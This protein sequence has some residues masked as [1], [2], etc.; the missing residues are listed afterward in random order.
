[1]TRVG[2]VAKKGVQ[3]AGSIAWVLGLLVLV[4]FA[5]IVKLLAQAR[6]LREESQQRAASARLLSEGMKL[7]EGKPWSDEFMRGLEARIAAEEAALQQMREE[8]RKR[9][10]RWRSSGPRAGG[11][12]RPSLA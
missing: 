4:L 8:K 12:P 2:Q 9:G 7:A 3:V 1:L 10:W 5:W 11:T 6:R